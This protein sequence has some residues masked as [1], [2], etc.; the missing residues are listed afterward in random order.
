[1]RWTVWPLERRERETLRL[2]R[3]TVERWVGR[4]ANLFLLAQQAW[5]SEN[6]DGL[7]PALRSLYS[8][9]PARP[10]DV[11]IESALL[12]LLLAD[13]GE[14]V[15]SPAQAEALIRHRFGLLCD[16]G[17]EP[18]DQWD[19]RV[20]HRAGERHALGYGMPAAL[21]R[22]LAEAAQ[23]LGLRWSVWLPACLWGLQRERAR[24]KAGWWAWPEQDRLLLMR[25][26]RGRVVALNPAVD[27]VETSDALA[28]RVR[29]ENVRYGFN[30]SDLAVRAA[31]WRPVTDLPA[32]TSQVQWLSIVGS[33]SAVG[34]SMPSSVSSGKA[35]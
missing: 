3:T 33:P 17:T 27:L 16:R 11:V 5:A 34:H 29:I 15:W 2:G 26:E 1:M 8:Q 10:I 30:L 7:A 6:V 22:G 19:V 20:D 4:G 25:M 23:Q 21:K 35:Q 9:A 12:P 31:S 13:T 24:P 18:V 32:G 14:R 28:Q